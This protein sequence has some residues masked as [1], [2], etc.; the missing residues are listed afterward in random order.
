[1]GLDN[2]ADVD[3]DDGLDDVDGGNG[4]V[5]VVG[6]A[7]GDGAVNCSHADCPVSTAPLLSLLLLLLLPSFIVLDNLIL[8]QRDLYTYLKNK[9]N[10]SIW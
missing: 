8:F 9:Q 3:D 1:M 10:I 5:G 7:G 4:V 6:A 2:S